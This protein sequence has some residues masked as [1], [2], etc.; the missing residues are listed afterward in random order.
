M[1]FFKK[2]KA[3]I[4]FVTLFAFICLITIFPYAKFVSL[5]KINKFNKYIGESQIILLR[6]YEKAETVLFYTDE[7]ARLS[8]KETIYE[9]GDSVLNNCDDYYG[10][11]LWT[12]ELDCFPDYSEDEIKNLVIEKFKE[13]FQLYLDNYPGKIP[14]NLDDYNFELNQENE[15]VEIIGKTQEKLRMDITDDDSIVLETSEEQIQEKI[16]YY[17]MNPSFRAKLNFNIDFFIDSIEKAET[18][19]QELE[20]EFEIGNQIDEEFITDFIGRKNYYKNFNIGYC[21]TF[22]EKEKICVEN[23]KRPFFKNGIFTENCYDCNHIKV[24]FLGCIDYPNQDY[25]NLDLCD[26][27]CIWNGVN[28]VK[29]SFVDLDENISRICISSEYNN[30][31]FNHEMEVYREI[32]VTMKFALEFD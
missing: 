28:C 32:P 16:G 18:L 19:L 5:K 29:K 13:N 20:Q 6:T 27:N 21:D 11:R 17:Y 4:F 15:Y 7:S 30:F 12:P 3:A 25:C 26:K 31:Q 1:N 22:S 10:Y 14:L 24:R 9:L 23:N 8:L 2:R